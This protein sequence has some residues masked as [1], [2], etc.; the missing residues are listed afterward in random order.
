MKSALPELGEDALDW[1]RSGDEKNEL[2]VA[3]RGGNFGAGAADLSP[4]DRVVITMQ[5]IE[6]CS[7]KEIAAAT[8]RVGHRSARARDA[9]AGEIE[10]RSGKIGEVMNESKLKQLFESARKET[11]PAPPPDFAADVLRAVHREPPAKRDGRLFRFST[12]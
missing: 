11:A 5:E 8:G 7:V 1:L 9:G 3:R 2:D 12:S 6:G 10:T 4:A